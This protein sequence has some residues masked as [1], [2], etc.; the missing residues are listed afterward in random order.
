MALI[1]MSLIWVAYA[2]AVAILMI[3]AIT[4]VFLYQGKERAASVSF[5]AI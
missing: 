5:P 3:M 2:V 1:Q 4:F